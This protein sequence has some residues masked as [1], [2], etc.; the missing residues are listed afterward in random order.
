MLLCQV[1]CICGSL[2]AVSVELLMVGIVLI[3]SFACSLDPFSPTRYDLQP[4][5]ECM[6]PI[7]L[8]LLCLVQLISSGVLLFFEEKQKISGSGGC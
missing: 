8:N 7:L 3:D 2:V 6:C 5:Y 4:C 1:F